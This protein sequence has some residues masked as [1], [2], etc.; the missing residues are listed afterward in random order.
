MLLL[1]WR[2]LLLLEVV[3][4]WDVVSG[5]LLGGP[6][7]TSRG[8]SSRVDVG[9]LLLLMVVLLGRRRRLL[10]VVLLLPMIHRL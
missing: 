2:W 4:L 6:V 10:V 5:E 1:W 7:L 9:L 8:V 3:L